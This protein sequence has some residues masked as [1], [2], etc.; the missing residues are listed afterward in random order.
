[1]KSS[2]GGTIPKKIWL[3]ILEN[4]NDFTGKETF[5]DSTALPGILKGEKEREQLYPERVFLGQIKNGAGYPSIAVYRIEPGYLLDCHNTVHRVE[6]VIDR[7]TRWIHCNAHNGAGQED[8]ELW[9][10]GLVM[11]F[12]LQSRGIFTLHGAA[13]NYGGKAIA[14]L[15]SNGYGKSTLALYLA[16]NGHPVITD[17]V[18]PIIETPSSLV[19]HPGWPSMNLW[20]QTL[21]Y[22]EPKGSAVVKGK[23]RYGIDLLN[24]SHCRTGVPLHRVYLLQPKNPD[25]EAVVQIASVIGAQAVVDL[26]SYTRANTMIEIAAQKKLLA[27][28]SR[29]ISQASVRRLTVTRGLQYLPDVYRAISEDVLVDPVR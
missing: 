9:L 20:S 2:A 25:G 10:F 4:G 27:T 3:P 17:D 11:S 8:I 7:D 29:L 26:L 18:L 23:R 15:G 12:V 22:F 1:M 24:V 21:D 13:V 6:F 28:Y 5:E 19:A 14:F 16:K